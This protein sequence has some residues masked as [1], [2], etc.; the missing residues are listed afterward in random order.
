MQEKW[1]VRRGDGERSP[2]SR[3][4]PRPVDAAAFHQR[5]AGAIRGRP[6]ARSRAVPSPRSASRSR[7]H[8]RG[9]LR[10]SR[11]IRRSAFDCLSNESG[12]DYPK[13]ERDRGRLPSL[14]VL[15]S[16]TP[17]CEGRRAARQP[18]DRRRVSA[19]LGAPRSGRS[20]R[21]SISSASSSRAIPTCG[22]SSCP[23]TGSAIR[24][25]RISSSRRSTTA[26]APSGRACCEVS[27]DS[28]VEVDVVARTA[29]RPRR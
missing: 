2:P 13:R 25:A 3:R 7:R 1:L 12:V 21:S 19:R 9:L 6:S 17:A 16:V 27:A 4:R 15:R 24:C 10:T 22:A 29:S 18:D 20:G 8:R 5:S 11:A 26:S 14:L 23:R 28:D